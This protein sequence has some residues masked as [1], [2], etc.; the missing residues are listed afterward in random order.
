MSKAKT[1]DVLNL[2]EVASY[3][4]MPVETIAVQAEQGQIPG[5]KI[6]DTWRFLKAAVDD[7]LRSVDG[8][9][10]LLQQAG[11]LADDDTL[12]AL[13]RN[14]YQSRKRSDVVKR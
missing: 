2:E 14:I 3:L 8:R 12:A 6:E 5:R 7:W 10:L 1:H 9:A 4:R 13:R 11:A